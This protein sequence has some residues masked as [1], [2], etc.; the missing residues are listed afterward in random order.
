MSQMELEQVMAALDGSGNQRIGYKDVEK[1][2][3]KGDF[4][5]CGSL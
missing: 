4:M 2:H 1:A 5:T 3:L